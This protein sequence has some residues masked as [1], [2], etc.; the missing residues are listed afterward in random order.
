MPYM[1]TFTINIP[2]MLASIYHTWI[3]W[4][5]IPSLLDLLGPWAS[6]YLDPTTND[7][8]HAPNLPTIPIPTVPEHD[9]GVAK[10]SLLG[11]RFDC[12]DLPIL[13]E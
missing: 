12:R 8:H 3:L 7:L 1:V 4:A 11:A 2:P 9:Q 6:L 13:A 10:Q 5:M